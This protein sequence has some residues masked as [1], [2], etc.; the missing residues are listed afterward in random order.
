MIS[1]QQKI[2][3]EENEMQLQHMEFIKSSVKEKNKELAVQYQH[4]RNTID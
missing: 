2:I 3:K 4:Q 1:R